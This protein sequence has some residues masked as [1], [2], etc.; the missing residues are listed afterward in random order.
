M[1]GNFSEILEKYRL[2]CR[3]AHNFRKFE[4]SYV[5]FIIE[6]L[7]QIFQNFT[8]MLRK[9]E[10]LK[11]KKIV[12]HCLSPTIALQLLL[13]CQCTTAPPPSHHIT[14][15]PQHPICHN[16]NLSACEWKTSRLHHAAI[17]SIIVCT[18][19]LLPASHRRLPLHFS[20]CST[21]RF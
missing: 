4:V 17:I 1:K 8:N 2:K 3:F 10:K 18:A 16:G 12:T 11:K 15:P 14:A 5:F 20:L 13:L 7:Q 19:P 9:S 6:I 21:L